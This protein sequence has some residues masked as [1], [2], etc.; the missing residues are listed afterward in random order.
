MGPIPT[1]PLACS[2]LPLQGPAPIPA[3]CSPSQGTAPE[4]PRDARGGARLTIQVL[5]SQDVIPAEDEI[6]AE[7]LV[8]GR[9]QGALDGGV[10][11][12]QRVAD[13]VCHHDEEV[14]PFAT[15]QGPAL[16]TVEVGFSASGEEGVS[17]GTSWGHES[18]HGLWGRRGPQLHAKGGGHMQ[19][20]FV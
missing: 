5:D 9:H 20:W 1:M 15:V 12:P 3:P 16:G 2:P 10:L 11:Q 4:E 19:L 7:L 14:A 13:L 8:V 17:Q 18:H 6:L